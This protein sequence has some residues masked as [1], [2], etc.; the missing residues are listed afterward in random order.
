VRYLRVY[1]DRGGTRFEDCEVAF[2]SAAFAPP[3]PPIDVSAAVPTREL[4]FIR[5]D[6]GWVDPSHPSPARQWMFVLSGQGEITAG[7]E[8]RTWRR[9]DVLLLED[10]SAPGH[11]TTVIDDALLAVVRC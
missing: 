5:F 3:A 1:N 7:A 10:T 11:G 4:L 6:A 8:T 9:G 2:A